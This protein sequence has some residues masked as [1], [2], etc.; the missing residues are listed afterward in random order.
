MGV[1]VYT[2]VPTPFRFGASE[3]YISTEIQ[4]YERMAIGFNYYGILFLN[5]HTNAWHMVLEDCGALIGTDASR[6]KLINRIK[7]DVSTGDPEVMQRQVEMGKKQM[8]RSEF[9]QPEDWFSKFKKEREIEI[10]E[11]AP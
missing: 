1:K 4:E 9:L 11:S 5:P 3:G 6:S 7:D 2:S 10:D 8:E